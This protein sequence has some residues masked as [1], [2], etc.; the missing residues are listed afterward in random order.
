MSLLL[1]THHSLLITHHSSLITLHGNANVYN[2]PPLVVA[3]GRS[4]MALT[5]PSA[6]VPSRGSSWP[7]TMAPD[8][9]PTPLRIETYCLPSGPRNVTG[10]PMIPEPTLNCHSRSPV[11]AS[12][13]LNQPSIVP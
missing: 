3:F 11:R 9:P 2:I 1:I 8:H 13:A 10:W 6:A 12:T 7:G 4:L 5:N